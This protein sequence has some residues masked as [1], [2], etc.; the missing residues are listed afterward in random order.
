LTWSEAGTEQF[1]SQQEPERTKPRLQI[2]HPWHG[3]ILNRHDGTE[4]ADA[5]TISVQGTAPEGARVTVNGIPA[6]MRGHSFECAVPLRQ[7]ENVIACVGTAGAAKCEHSVKVFWDKGSRPR[8]RFSVDDNVEFLKDLGTR[9]EDYPSLFDHWYLAFWRRMH[10]G[11]GAK[12]HLNIYYQTVEQDFTLVQLPQKWSEEW[13]AS[14][15]WLRLTFHALQDMPARIYKDATYDQIARD[16]DLVVSE[17]KRFAGA[18]L[19]SRATTVHWAEAPKD[20]CR[21]L[22]DRGIRVLIGLFDR[23]PG[24][25]LTTGYYLPEATKDHVAARDCWHD[26]ETHLTFVTCDAVVNGLALDQINAHLDNQAASPHTGELIELLIH[27]QY[28]RKEFAYCQPDVQDKVIRALE[29][30]TKRG[31]EPVFWGDQCL[32]DLADE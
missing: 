12:I 20:A 28:F 15:D 22:Y 24:G 30:V 8:Y 27:E 6:D 21:A 4:T 16:F 5:L 9:P 11:F 3:D 1:M 13:H 31:Y 29:W 7:R 10:Q 25:E 14:A 17:I 2:T 18:S 32:A 26:P 19:L 23:P